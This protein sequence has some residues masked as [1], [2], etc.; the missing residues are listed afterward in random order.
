M[1]WVVRA[2]QEDKYIDTFLENKRI[3][4]SWEGF[5]A[6]LMECSDRSDFRMIVEQEMNTTNRTS[7]SN[8]SGQLY[9]FTY[10]MKCGDYVIIPVK[11]SRTYNL[12]KIVGEYEFSSDSVPHHSRQIELLEIDIPREVFSQKNQYSLAAYRTIFKITDD[13]IFD[14]IKKWKEKKE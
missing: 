3:Y 10:E 6:S 2:G 14:E 5:N 4:I 13:A 9:T 1:L 7:I 8:W 12:G 11:R